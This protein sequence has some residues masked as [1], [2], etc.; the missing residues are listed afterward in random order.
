MREMSV[1]EQRYKAYKAVLAVV[2]GGRMVG[3]VSSRWA[4]SLQNSDAGVRGGVATRLVR[5]SPRIANHASL[6]KG[7]ARPDPLPASRPMRFGY[8]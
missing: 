7:R 2:A 1:T 4:W 5:S 8:Q 3:E 6:E